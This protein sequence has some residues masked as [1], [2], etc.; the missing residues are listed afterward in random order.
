LT[1]VSPSLEIYS[2][3]T[4]T[5]QSN[6]LSIPIKISG[7]EVKEN[8][9]TLGLIDSGAEGKFINQNY[10][11]TEGFKLHKLETPLRAYNVDGTE[12]KR[13]TIKNYIKL[14]QEINGRKTKTDLFITRLGKE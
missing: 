1:P 5:I 8:V 13:G 9:K 3:T 7:T 4:A 12:N 11:K 6:K 2:V 10:A 14:K